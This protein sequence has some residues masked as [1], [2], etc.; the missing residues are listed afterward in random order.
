MN[1]ERLCRLCRRLAEETEKSVYIGPAVFSL[2]LNSPVRKGKRS[3]ILDDLV[4][5]TKHVEL[6]RF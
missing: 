3:G 1:S 5:F 6:V 2:A 4:T